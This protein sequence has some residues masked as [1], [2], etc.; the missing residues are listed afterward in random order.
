MN[1]DAIASIADAVAALAV[2][3][4]LVYLA[5]QVKEQN[6]QSKL[7]A[8]RELARDWAN[9]LG[10]LSRNDDLFDLYM[11]A[12]QGYENLSGADRVKA[13]WMFSSSW[14][15]VEIQRLHLIEG[16]FSAEQFDRTEFRIK[17][18]A[19]FPGVRQF[20]AENKQQFSPDFVQH[21]EN[22]STISEDAE[23]DAGSKD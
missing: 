2:I 9:G 22:V 20:W 1:W 8:V 17:E 10:E 11:R 3:I 15:A 14:R 5:V 16:H 13:Y 6:K 7:T 19:S 18:I 21:V 12:I 4:T 23:D